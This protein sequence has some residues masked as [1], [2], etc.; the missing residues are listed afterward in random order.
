MVAWIVRSSAA[1]VF[2]ASLAGCGS[3]APHRARS[4]SANAPAAAAACTP[5]TEHAFAALV[6]AHAV[7]GAAYS[8]P[9]GSQGC[10]LRMIGRGAPDVHV[11]LRTDDFPQ[12]FARLNRES[13]EATQ[14]ALWSGSHKLPTPISGLGEMAFWFPAESR[15][16]ATDG[17]R[18]V[19]VA[20]GGHVIAPSRRRALARRLTRV[21][22]G[23]G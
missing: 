6:G 15:L 1:V 7:T 14:N 5:T 21:V 16:V 9:D 2:C 23:S 3:G 18:L 17:T 4:G 13:V 8:P 11:D 10:R 12:P 19:S 20:V 22:L